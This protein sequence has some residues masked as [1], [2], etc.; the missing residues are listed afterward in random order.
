MISF[1]N[2]CNSFEWGQFFHN[3]T[4]AV[5]DGEKGNEW[6]KQ[7]GNWEASGYNSRAHGFER[8]VRIELEW[9]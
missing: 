5:S 6:F 3:P 4:T 1:Q 7:R 2:L 9:Y 8:R